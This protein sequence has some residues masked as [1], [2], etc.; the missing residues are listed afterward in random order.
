MCECDVR[1]GPKCAVFSFFFFLVHVHCTSLQPPLPDY[2]PSKIEKKEQILKI[3]LRTS[4][5]QDNTAAMSKR[6]VIADSDDDSDVEI[7]TLS[8]TKR[9][10]D[11][12]LSPISNSSNDDCIVIEE[13]KVVDGNSWFEKRDTATITADEKRHNIEVAKKQSQLLK[14]RR[15]QGGAASPSAPPPVSPLIKSRHTTRKYESPEHD[16]ISGDVADYDL[17]L[18]LLDDTP[19]EIKKRGETGMAR[20]AKSK[21]VKQNDRSNRLLQR[22]SGRQEPLI[23]VDMSEERGGHSKDDDAKKKKKKN[24]RKDDSDD[25]DDAD[26][27]QFY[28]G[29][30]D[31]DGDDE[32]GDAEEERKRA[33]LELKSREVIDRCSDL[34]VV[35]RKALRSWQDGEEEDGDPNCVNLCRISCGAEDRAG[36]GAAGGGG[37]TGTHLLQQRDLAVVCPSMVLKDYQLVGVNWLKLLHQNDVNGVLA[38]DMGLGKTVQTIAFL[39]W[40]FSCREDP[41]RLREQVKRAHEGEDEEGEGEEVKTDEVDDEREVEADGEGHV[42]NAQ[43]LPHLIVVPASTLANWCKEFEKFCPTLKVNN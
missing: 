39:A 18:A 42:A 29:G 1:C 12:I 15:L 9:S 25:D 40:L 22:E 7:A 23:L 4:I 5:N 38:D 31:S 17:R 8:V 26:G 33:M 14:R 10:E 41:E 11:A 35:L 16:V 19:D 24:K 34:S 21:M 36:V 43:I 30:G 20:L 3:H 6:R 37:E 28:G 2:R 32:R 13:T 27:Y